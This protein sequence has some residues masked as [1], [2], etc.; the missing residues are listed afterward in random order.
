[1]NEKEKKK[2]VKINNRRKIVKMVLL[3]IRGSN[4]VYDQIL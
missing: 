2:I 1:M 4:M 3:W